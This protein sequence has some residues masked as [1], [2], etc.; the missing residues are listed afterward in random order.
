[1]KGDEILIIMSKINV[2]SITTIV[3]QWTLPQCNLIGLPYRRF[4]YVIRFM[5]FRVIISDTRGLKKGMRA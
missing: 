1:V 3:G 5:F 2:S 4:Y